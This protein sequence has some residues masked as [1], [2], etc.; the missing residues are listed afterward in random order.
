MMYLS[1]LTLD[2]GQRQARRDL[3]NRYDLH[4]TLCRAFDAPQDA[5]PL[6]RLELLRPGEPPRL[7]VQSRTTPDWARVAAEHPGYLADHGGKPL[8]L[9]AQLTSGQ[10]LRFRLEANPTVTRDGKRHGLWREED[11]LAWLNRQAARGGFAVEAAVVT[12]EERLALRKPGQPRPIVLHAV[13]FD[14]RLVVADPALLAAALDSG[15]GHGKALGLGLLSLG[16]G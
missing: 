14:G 8:D 5:R 13:L 4:R 12:R 2:P 15:L 7:L 16:R 1:Q 10:R 6:W 11:Q 3:A 9:A